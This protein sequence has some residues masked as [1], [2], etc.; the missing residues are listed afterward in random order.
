MNQKFEP[1]H[2][3]EEVA[4]NKEKTFAE[5]YMLGEKAGQYAIHGGG[6]PVRVRGVEGVV[7][8]AVV[9]GLKQHEDHAVVV[10]GMLK[11]IKQVEER[12]T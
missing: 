7:G 11:I 12:T 3:G 4:E 9:S 5:K 6:V 8:V 10:E 2:K 1:N